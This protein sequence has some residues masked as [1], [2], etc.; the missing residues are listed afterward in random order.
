[1]SFNIVITFHSSEINTAHYLVDILKKSSLDQIYLVDELKPVNIETRSEYLRK[2]SVLIVL[3]SR[4]FQNERY[5]M[6]LVNFGRD[7]K[8]DIFS[9]N[10]SI[11]FRP[12]G[13]LGAII[14]GSGRQLIEIENEQTKEIEIKKLIIDL[15]QMEQLGSASNEPIRP[16]S[17]KFLFDLKLNDEKLDILVSFH[18]KQELNAKLLEK[19]LAKDGYSFKLEDSTSQT[20]CVKF[21]RTVIIVMSNDYENSD[22]SKSVVDLARSLK[23]NII[24]VSIK[25]GWKSDSW[26]GLVIAGKLFF[27]VISQEQVFEKKNDFE[28]TPMDNIILEVAKSLQTRPDESEREL[29]FRKAVEKK[30]EECREK[31]LKWPPPR[32]LRPKKELKP[33]KVCLKK[34]QSKPNQYFSVTHFKVER[35]FFLPETLYDNFGV[36]KRQ[37]FDGMISY[38]WSS[39]ELVKNIFMNFYMKN[40]LIWFDVWGY[41]QGCTYDAMATAI[42]CS[43]VIV[44]FLTN[45]YQ[46][47]ANCQLEFKYAIARGK[48]FI[49]II[50]EDNIILEQWIEPYFLES[51]KFE[52][53]HENDQDILEDGVPRF[54][55]ICQAIRDIGF[56]QMELEDECLD[57]SEETIRLKETLDDALDELDE[58]NGTS[59]FKECTRCHKKFDSEYNEN[60]QCFKHKEYF[61]NYWSCCGQL[62]KDSVGCVNVNHTNLKREWKKNI[63]YGTFTWEP[64]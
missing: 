5:C 58:Q 12:Y 55:K 15:K 44:V 35:T 62:D 59:R 45:R 3:C 33:V 11:H 41:M 54:Y 38:Q 39:Q 8:K 29:Q 48:P 49:F 27:R 60:M 46:S 43:K 9:I 56:S 18:P 1:M 63:D 25:K 13:A 10:T 26:L 51:P 61:I 22:V 14:A 19:G 28:F 16:K 36:P 30:C 53:K 4:K 34:L 17:R 21:C 47:S 52:I 23:K 32:R 24:P 64:A 31:L 6:E 37:R 7:L 2:S 20:T 42:E 50:V 40:L 57:F